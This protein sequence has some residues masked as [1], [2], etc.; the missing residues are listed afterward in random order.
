[1][2]DNSVRI[3]VQDKS[4]SWT[5]IMSGV[6]KQDQVIKIRLD[7]AVKRSP[8]GRARAIDSKGSIIDLR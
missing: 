1:M 3:Q 2:A 8:T 4:G 7:G 5:T 6:Q